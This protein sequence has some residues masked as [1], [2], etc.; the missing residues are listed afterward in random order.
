[1]HASRFDQ[2]IHPSVRSPQPVPHAIHGATQSPV[3]LSAQR[4]KGERE[5]KEEVSEPRQAHG[6]RCR[7][8][9]RLG[10]PGGRKLG[11][12]NGGR[13]NSCGSPLTLSFDSEE[14]VLAPCHVFGAVW[15]GGREHCHVPRGPRCGC[16]ASRP[17]GGGW[18]NGERG[19]DQF[20]DRDYYWGRD[21]WFH[22]WLND[23]QLIFI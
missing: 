21:R 6:G 18:V 15:H 14:P 20:V 9:E 10:D 23:S 16:T 12:G 22:N 8:R 17:D 5:R 3:T 4:R 19:T 11:D 2:P 1:M 7:V 13:E